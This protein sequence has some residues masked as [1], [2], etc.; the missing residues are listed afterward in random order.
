MKISLSAQGVRYIFIDRKD[1]DTPEP[2]QTAFRQQYPVAFENEFFAVLENPNCLAP[3]FLARN[4]VSI[5][6]DSYAYSAADLGLI[7]LYFLPVE[8]TGVEMN[9]PALA[10]VMNPQNGEVEL[11]QAFRDREGEPFRIL[12]ASSLKREGPNRIRVSLP[13]EPFWVTITQ[14]WHPDW[15][16]R[17]DGQEVELSRIALA[18]A[19]FRAV[20]GSREAT[21]SY[22]PPFWTSA[23][24]F[25]GL[26]GWVGG[27]GGAAYLRFGPAPKPWKRWW[28]GEELEIETSAE[29]VAAKKKEE[30]GQSNTGKIQKFLVIMPTYNEGDTIQQVLEEVQAKAPGVEILVVDDNSPDGTAA[31]VKQTPNFGKKIHLLERPGKA[32]LGSAYKEGFQWAMKR[33]YD[34]VVEMDADL[35]HDPADVPKLLQAL[36]DGAD[37]AVGSRYLHGVRVLNW[38]Q[39]RLWVSSFGGWYARMLTGLPMTDPTSGFKAIRRRVLEGLDWEKFTAQGYGFQIEIHFL[40]WQGGFRLVE[41]PIVFTERREGQSKMSLQIA[42]EAAWRVLQLAVR[43]IF[44]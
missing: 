5:P 32:G 9:D 12:D 18:L 15:K 16:V 30:K 26:I 37:L 33:G 44:P 10:G 2:L 42:Q 13:G 22:E 3:G 19:G 25:L 35:S 29:K 20:P 43:R 6:K 17:L 40:A 27:L 39:S 36:Q 8:L 11:T 4:Y 24:L 14:A 7:R 21:L 28:E 34:A 1:V 31:K 41:V 38:P 23:V